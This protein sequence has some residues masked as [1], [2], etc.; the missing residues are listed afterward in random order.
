MEKA[1]D[2]VAV[3]AYDIHSF[4]C[5]GAINILL[6]FADH[7]NPTEQNVNTMKEKILEGVRESEENG[8]RGVAVSTCCE[9]LH[10]C[11]IMGEN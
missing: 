1:A 11:Y 3:I 8:H 10:K 2:S 7:D 9:V 4:Y 6:K 5:L